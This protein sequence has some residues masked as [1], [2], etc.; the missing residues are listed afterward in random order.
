MK[1]LCYV[2]SWQKQKEGVARLTEMLKSKDVELLGVRSQCKSL[3]ED[4]D[5]ER[6]R[7]CALEEELQA[8][9]H[10]ASEEMSA[11]PRG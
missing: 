3:Q 2:N 8:L 1:K 9:T 7:S 6:A 5:Q 4:L 10:N 11:G